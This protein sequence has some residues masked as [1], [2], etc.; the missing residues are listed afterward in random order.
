[1]WRPRWFQNQ[2]PNIGNVFTMEPSKGDNDPVTNGSSALFSLISSQGQRDSEQGDDGRARLLPSTW[3]KNTEALNGGGQS[4]SQKSHKLFP[5]CKSNLGGALDRGRCCPKEEEFRCRK[6]ELW[7]YWRGGRR[8]RTW[9]LWSRYRWNVGTRSGDF[10]LPRRQRH[11]AFTLCTSAS[12]RVG[13]CE[14]R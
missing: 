4:Q 13:S 6:D 8:R 1:M 2:R 12:K 10:K 3:K 9:F 7:R 5:N 14:T 11:N